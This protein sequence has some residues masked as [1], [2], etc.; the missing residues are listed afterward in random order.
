MLDNAL[1]IDD[2]SQQIGDKICEANRQ[3]AG[4]QPSSERSGRGSATCYAALEKLLNT[5]VSR[6]IFCSFAEPTRSFTA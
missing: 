4:A 5:I 2:Q 3:D 6:S 1:L